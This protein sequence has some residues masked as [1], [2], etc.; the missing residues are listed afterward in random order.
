MKRSTLI[1]ARFLAAAFCLWTAVSPGMTACLDAPAPAMAAPGTANLKTIAPHFLTPGLLTVQAATPQ[2]SGSP[3]TA[4]SARIATPSVIPGGK[5]GET[6]PEKKPAGY[7]FS[8]TDYRLHRSEQVREEVTS[9][10]KG[11]SARLT[12]RLSSSALTGKDVKKSDFSV[13]HRRDGYRADGS[14]TVKIL[15]KK[16]DPLELQITF[17]KITYLGGDT[18]FGFQIRQK[19]SLEEAVSLSVPI[20]E[21]ERA[22]VSKSSGKKR[23][24][25]SSVSQ[26]VIR[27]ER[28]GTFSPMEPGGSAALT[29]RLSNLSKETDVED[30]TAVLTPGPSLYL[31]GDTNSVIVGKLK[32]GQSTEIQVGLQAGQDLS[33]VSQTLD[34]ELRYNYDADGQTAAVTSAQKVTVPIREN[35][36][37]G[38]PFIRISHMRNGGEIGAGQAFQT[39]I[40]LENTSHS[41]VS[42]LILTLEPSDQ[43]ALMDPE[44]T[45]LVGD[46]AP[47]QTADVT[48]NLKTS[49]EL[50]S[51]P[52]QLV[53]VGLKFDYD[54]GKGTVQGSI[55]GKIVVLTAGGT[56]K[57]GAPTPNLIIRSYSYGGSAQAGQ[58]FDLVMEVANTSR[59]L[60]A[61]NILMSLNTGEGLSINDSSNTIYI[62]SLAPG[63]TETRTVRMQALFQSKLL[64][65]KVDISFKYEYV[66]NR[67]RKQ[68]STAETIS[69]PV[70]QPDRLEVKS[71]SF[72]DG[73][74]AQE[75][76][77][78]SLPYANKGRGDLFNLEARLEGDI[79]V[80]EREVSLGNLEPGKTGTIDFLVT[81]E[82]GGSF[83]GQVIIAY[84][85]DAM[86]RKELTVPVK[87]Q[88]K[89]APAPDLPLVPEETERSGS[90]LPFY[91]TAVLLAFAGTGAAVFVKRK[92]KGKQENLEETAEDTG[93]W[94]TL[95]WDEEDLETPQ[96]PDSSREEAR[97][98]T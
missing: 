87:F 39:T 43:I 10:K 64:S 12:I 88:I 33:G 14:P 59:Q 73:V 51:L 56:S 32:A 98:E 69:I 58:V 22:D 74:Q 27:L 8:V 26:P 20:D 55:S 92:R 78:I 57:L 54:S 35:S 13:S 75:E 1:R 21:T 6:S 84:E 17:P 93:D 60:P 30:L 91:L 82:T 44:D 41:Q 29:L 89:D 28:A 40:R 94:E 37:S 23:N 62:P 19:G 72:P 48:V 77:A 16:D 63:A 52:S 18:A 65:P 71:P 90:L 38:Q 47:G 5:G 80:L 68:N 7:A 81:P 85:D 31:T 45:Y 15:S 9:L 46:L 3:G 34:V 24:R 67:E 50:S 53:G 70:Y 96:S 66:D 49:Q 95:D 25:D 2:P 79:P 61:E 4:A 42:G 36:S 83:E 97:H 11:E 86:N 76:T